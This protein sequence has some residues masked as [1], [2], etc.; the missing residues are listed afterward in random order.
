MSAEDQIP[1]VSQ[2]VRI[3]RAEQ[4][5]LRGD[6]G[7]DWPVDVRLQVTDDGWGIHTGDAQY[8]VDHS[9]HWGASSFDRDSTPED[10][11]G[12]ADDLIEQVNES[13][14]DTVNAP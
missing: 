14:S 10:L 1:P 9:G 3:L 2:I 12:V 6:A 8:D 5:I 11:K 13:L 4:R 7:I